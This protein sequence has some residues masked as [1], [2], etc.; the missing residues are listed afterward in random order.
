MNHVCGLLVGGFE[1]H[2]V[3]GTTW[4]P[5]YYLELLRGCGYAKVEDLLAYWMPMSGDYE[6]P[7][8]VVRLSERVRSRAGLTF[9]DV[10]FGR[11]FWDDV[12]KIWRLYEEAWADN[13]GFVPPDWEEFQHL[14]RSLKPVMGRDFS[15]IA[16]IDGEEV[17]FMLVAHDLNR[18]LK[19]MPSGR[20][21][22]WNLFKILWRTRRIFSG[23]MLLAGIKAGRRSL[24]PL[25]VHEAMRR[26]KAVDAEGAEASWILEENETAC[27]PL[28]SLGFAPYRRWRILEKP[29]R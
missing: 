7:E 27:A 19:T 26:G 3:V 2:P 13:W 15:F 11:G 9:R 20:L 6:I 12:R 10:N 21:W 18:V 25:F 8:R 1:E 24:L 29:L 16:E 14:A 17:G 5:P 22:P 4:N 23:R 28:D